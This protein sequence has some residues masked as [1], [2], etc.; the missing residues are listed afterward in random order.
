[1][2]YRDGISRKAQA[3]AHEERSAE[4]ERQVT[5]ISDL[6]PLARKGQISPAR[7]LQITRDILNGDAD[8]VV[9]VGEQY[10]PDIQTGDQ[11]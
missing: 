6:V 2:T 4:Q 11:R 9:R 1:M 8:R 3:K 10:R 7:F 5:R